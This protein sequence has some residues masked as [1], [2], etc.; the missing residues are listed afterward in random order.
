MIKSVLKNVVLHA[1]FLLVVF[2]ST[3]VLACE[4]FVKTGTLLRMD[5]GTIQHCVFLPDGEKEEM[6]L[7]PRP[8]RDCTP[9]FN[10]PI[11]VEIRHEKVKVPGQYGS[12]DTLWLEKITAK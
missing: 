2:L 1:L 8:N 12:V 9:H 7:T 4:P 5:G 11:K 10:K 6:Y 3:P